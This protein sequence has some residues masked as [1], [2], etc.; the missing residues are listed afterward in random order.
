M[1]GTCVLFER[2]T[3]GFVVAKERTLTFRSG[4]VSDPLTSSTI[5]IF[6]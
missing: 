5:T 4:C 1:K 3:C 6:T 2:Q